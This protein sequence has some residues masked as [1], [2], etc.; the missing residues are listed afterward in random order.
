[1]LVTKVHDGCSKRCVTALKFKP[2]KSPNITELPYS[3]FIHLHTVQRYKQLVYDDDVNNAVGKP[4][5]LRNIYRGVETGLVHR[6]TPALTT[7]VGNHNHS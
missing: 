1:M 2:V 7:I 4:E 6:C 3:N 5:P